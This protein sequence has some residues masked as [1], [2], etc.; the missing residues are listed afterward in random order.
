M[1]SLT[2]L[3]DAR[4]SFCCGVTRW[5]ADQPQIVA[6][7]FVPAGTSEAQRRFPGLDHRQTMSEVTVVADT[8]EVYVADGAWLACLWATRSHRQLAEHLARRPG[9]RAVRTAVAAVALARPG[10]RA[11]PRGS[12][13]ACPDGGCDAWLR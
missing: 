10:P 12:R 13:D 3:Y 8:G 7:D 11:D 4:C 1:R 9:R 2:V 5:L 6:L